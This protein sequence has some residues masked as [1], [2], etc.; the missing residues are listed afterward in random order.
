MVLK[1]LKHLKAHITRRR[2]SSRIIVPLF[3]LANIQPMPEHVKQEIMKLYGIT[4]KDLEN[5]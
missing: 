5:K 3:N 2:F 4:Q 1:L